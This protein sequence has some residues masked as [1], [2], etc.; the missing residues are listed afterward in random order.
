MVIPPLIGNPYNGYISPYGIG[1]FPIPYHTKTDG[2][3]DPIAHVFFAFCPERFGCGF[4]V[5]HVKSFP[6]HL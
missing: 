1:E 6:R 5:L 2:I 4:P 3:L